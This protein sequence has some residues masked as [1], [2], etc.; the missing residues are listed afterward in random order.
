MIRTEWTNEWMNECTADKDTNRIFA[1]ITFEEDT[2]A[3]LE[4]TN[5]ILHQTQQWFQTL[6]FNDWD[7]FLLDHMIS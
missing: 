3:L 6:C 1:H 7:F 4:Q 5:Q 2:G